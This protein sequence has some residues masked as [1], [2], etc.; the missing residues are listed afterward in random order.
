MGRSMGRHRLV[1][2]K[3]VPGRVLGIRAM[4]S[5]GADGFLMFDLLFDTQLTRQ[6][7][8]PAMLKLSS[9]AEHGHPSPLLLAGF[10][11]YNGYLIES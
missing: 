9:C 8:R 4:S 1:E 11:R 2:A 6:T 3:A 5:A 7:R 10:T